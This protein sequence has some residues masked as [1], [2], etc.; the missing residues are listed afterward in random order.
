MRIADILKSRSITSIYMSGVAVIFLLTAVITASIIY[1]EYRAFDSEA[2][3]LK[4]SYLQEQKEVIKYDIDRVLGFIENQY[5]KLH[6]KMDEDILK[7]QVIDAIE[8]LYGRADGTGYIFIYSFDG[9]CLSDPIQR[10]HVGKN[11]FS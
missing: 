5:A 2:K 6:G 7:S 9:V 10:E 11:M 4:E 1:M 3:R 8:G